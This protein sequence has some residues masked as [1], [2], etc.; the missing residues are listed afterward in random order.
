MRAPV[1]QTLSVIII[2]IYGFMLMGTDAPLSNIMIFSPEVLQAKGAA[3]PRLIWQGETWRLGTA[4][5]LHGGVLHLFFN[6]FVLRQI[7]PL[8]EPTL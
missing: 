2:L 5:F 6:V 3:D 8:L 1:T 4:I 7:G